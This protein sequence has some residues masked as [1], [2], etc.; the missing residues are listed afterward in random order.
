MNWQQSLNKN[1]QYDYTEKIAAMNDKQLQSE[2]SSMIYMSAYSLNWNWKVDACYDE[3]I[4]RGKPE[5]YQAAY[6]QIVSG[7]V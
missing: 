1:N 6:K 5:I 2:I 7:A 3:C 4:R